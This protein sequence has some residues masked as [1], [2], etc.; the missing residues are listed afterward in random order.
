MLL[1]R[2][3]QLLIAN[4]LDT[5]LPNFLISKL[6]GI[7]LIYDSHEIFTEVPELYHN[8]LKKKIWELLESCII[9][10]LKFCVTVND[11]IAEFFYKKYGVPFLVV[12][13]IPDTTTRK[14]E[15]LKSRHELGLPEN[16]KIV[17]LQGAGINMDRGAEELVIAM[18][19]L[20]EDIM[21]LIIGGGDVLE[22]L[23][24]MTKDN[25]LTNKIRFI[26]KIPAE[27]LFH[28]T[29]NADLGITID[30]ET[31]LNYRFSLPNKIF[32]YIHAEVPILASRL[33]EIE[34]I[35]STY[36]I[37]D[38][39][40]QHDPRHIALKIEASL[41]HNDYKTW[42]LNLKTAKKENNWAKERLKWKNLF[43]SISNNKK[44]P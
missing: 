13:N 16:K 43:D 26:S 23:K 19:Y 8:R 44:I 33:V 36:T 41:A 34:K 6:K 28:F 24:Q 4:D 31:N 20:Q 39:I 17:L 15:N 35:I 5:L 29:G 2:K 18:K 42:K 1:T 11:S 38:F 10:K 12:R 27:E 32:D 21:L 9:P 30:K 40:D 37:G 25:S 14:L 3:S 22:K 7:P